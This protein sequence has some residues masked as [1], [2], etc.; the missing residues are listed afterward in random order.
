MTER[1]DVN[2]LAGSGAQFGGP[3]D[4]Y[5]YLLWRELGA[6][7]PLTYVMLNPSTAD[8]TLDDH[9]IRC[10]I[11]Y[12]KRE[13]AGKMLVVNLFAYRTSEPTVL[14]A[15]ARAGDDVVGPENDAVVWTALT[16]AETVVF[17][18]GGDARH[19]ALWPLG[20]VHRVA[21]LARK[22]G[23]RPFCLGTTATGMPRHPARLP[24]E[25]PLVPWKEP[26]A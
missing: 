5:R 12:A 24:T 11:R 2:L 13:G 3:A 25:M 26:A 1:L 17:A 23:R 19:P 8:G 22:A 4:R 9:T 10:C 7:P 16:E 21:Y 20:R 18:W 6:G 14:V 15:A